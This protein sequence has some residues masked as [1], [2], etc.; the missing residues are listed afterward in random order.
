M[1]RPRTEAAPSDAPR[2]K[3]EP[4]LRSRRCPAEYYPS[5]LS[6]VGDL[7]RIKKGRGR[8]YPDEEVP[9]RGFSSSQE[10]P[11]PVL[12]E[13]CARRFVLVRA[14][15]CRSAGQQPTWT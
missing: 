5:G 15:C 12:L 1:P 4:Q 11:I 10:P 2:R 8:T 13:L 14:S 6:G 7:Q 3:T 9:S